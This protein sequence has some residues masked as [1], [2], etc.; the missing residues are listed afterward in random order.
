MTQNGSA[1]AQE[2]CEYE[3]QGV[4]L[5]DK[6]LDWRLIDTAAKLSSQTCGSISQ[7]CDDWADTKATYRL[8]DNKKTTEWMTIIIIAEC[9]VNNCHECK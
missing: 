5:G 3:L 1:S 9:I 2:W 4:S 8:F 6:R 7:A